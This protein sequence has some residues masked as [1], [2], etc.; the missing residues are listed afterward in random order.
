VLG[1]A[2]ILSGGEPLTTEEFSLDIDDAPL[3][4]RE[5]GAV[6]VTGG[7]EK[8]EKQ[9]ILS[10]LEKT[11]GNKTEAARMLRISRRRLYSRMKVHGIKP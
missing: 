5:H 6:E 10:A 1:R 11:G 3:V 7:L 4:N 2:V 9:M 8:A